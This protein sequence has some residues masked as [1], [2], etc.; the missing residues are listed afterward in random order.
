M[1]R[2]K[3]ALSALLLATLLF[4]TSCGEHGW[5]DFYSELFGLSSSSEGLSN[6]EMPSSSSSYNNDNALG[7]VGP[8]LQTKWSQ[9]SPYSAKLSEMGVSVP[10]RTSGICGIVAWAQIMKY[11]KYPMRG[12]GQNEAWTHSNGVNL[13][14]VNFEVNF[15]W[16]NMLYTYNSSATEQ[17]RNAVAELYYII[18]IGKADNPLS[19]QNHFGYDKS[20]RRIYRKYYDDAA[21]E[22][23]IRAQLNA[24]LPVFYA[25]K[26]TKTDTDGTVT[27]GGHGFVI[28]GYDNEGKFHVNWGW[29]GGSDGWYF[30]NNLNPRNFLWDKNHRMDINFKPDQ[31]GVASYEMALNS[32]NASKTAISQNELFTVNYQFINTGSGQFPDGEAGIALVDNSGSIVAI[33]GSRSAG[34]LNA[35]STGSAREL[36]CFVPETVN[37]GQYKLRTVTKQTGEDWKLVELSAVGDGVPNSIPLTVTAGVAMADGH[38][39]ALTSLTSDITS[40]NQGDAVQFNV[41]ASFRNVSQ[42]TYAGGDWGIALVDNADKIVEAIGWRALSQRDPGANISV[43]SV[44]CRIPNT[45]A[46]GKYK[47]RLVVRETGGEWRISTL[48]IDGVPN[49]IDFEVK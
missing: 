49:S 17:Q 19:T 7:I 38:G 40:I 3:F 28:D 45:V 25:A 1:N 36:N 27:N 8:L 22:E 2:V 44:S 30:L 15:D 31:G 33:V 37:P 11:H 48:S 41:S 6:G 23:I 43:G 26:G 46:S 14:S 42:N 4:L 18:S 39:M 29:G 12:T 9:G 13:P 20:L 34:A 16:D 5:E 47:L 32:F 35:G 10:D 21:W 24:D